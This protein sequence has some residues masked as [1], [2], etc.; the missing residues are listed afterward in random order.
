MAHEAIVVEAGARLGPE[1]VVIDADPVFDDVERPIREQGVRAAP[2]RIA[3]GALLG[4]RVAVLRGVTVGPG[5]TVLAHSV[6]TRGVEPAAA[7]GGVPAHRGGASVP[8]PET[9]W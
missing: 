4:A 5:A 6:C 8:A 7:V 9:D 1:C 2:V 3:A